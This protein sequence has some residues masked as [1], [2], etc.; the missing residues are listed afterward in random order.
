MTKIFSITL[1]TCLLFIA[2]AKNGAESK[3]DLFKDF[4]LDLSELNIDF[5]KPQLV[6]YET[7]FQRD[8]ILK[9]LT[10][11][12]SESFQDPA[13]QIDSTFNKVTVSVGKEAKTIK[14]QLQND[15]D[16]SFTDWNNLG[17]CA[18]DRSLNE[19]MNSFL[20][21]NA[22]AAFGV[23]Y[24]KAANNFNLYAKK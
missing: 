23:E 7:E 24:I 3:D 5:T 21:K 13:N 22:T 6:K 16:I 12:L 2:C 4:K 10:E 18:D 17:I 14:I 1:L 20:A 8:S 11:E 19:K 9:G 15:S